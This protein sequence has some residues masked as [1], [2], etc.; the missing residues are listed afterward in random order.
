MK[1]DA[2][3]VLHDH[4]PAQLDGV[5]KL[6]SVVVPDVSVKN[7]VEHAEGRA[8]ELGLDGHP[9]DAK[10]VDRHGPKAGLGPIPTV[11]DPVLLNLGPEPRR[12][13]RGF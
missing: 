5:G 11:G 1:D 12:R 13:L 8:K 10:A 4:P 7:S 6:D 3:L 2:T 9:P